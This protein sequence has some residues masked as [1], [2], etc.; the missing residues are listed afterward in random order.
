MC[1]CYCDEGGIVLILEPQ[2]RAKDADIS[3]KVDQRSTQQNP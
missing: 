3:V 2:N 1:S